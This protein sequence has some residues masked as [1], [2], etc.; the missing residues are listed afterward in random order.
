[1]PALLGHAIVDRQAMADAG[2][3]ARRH[4]REAATDLPAMTASS[5][6]AA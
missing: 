4:T 2:S 6:S 5:L 3:E 1:V